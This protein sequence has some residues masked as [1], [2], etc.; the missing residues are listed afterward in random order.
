[1]T[2]PPLWADLAARVVATAGDAII[3]ADREGRVLLWNRGAEVMFGYPADEAIGET[4]DLIIPE[5]LRGRHWDGY[6]HTM[7]TGETRYAE[8]LLAVPGRRRDGTRVSL[9]FRVSI[10]FGADGRPEAITAVLRDVTRRREEDQAL[11][12]ELT[13]LQALVAERSGLE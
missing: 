2:D 10:L 6:R 11:R 4:L 9:E 3:A 5:G 13:R 1:M 7:E 12:E 8:Q